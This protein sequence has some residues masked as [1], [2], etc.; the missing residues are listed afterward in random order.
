M[1]LIIGEL[2][3]TF[4]GGG[5]V[6]NEEILKRL[7]FDF[8]FIPSTWNIYN[9]LT[10]YKYKEKLIEKINKLNLNVPDFIF[11]ILELKKPMSRLNI[12]KLINTKI[13]N[14][15]FD[16]AYAQE[17]LLED[18]FL[19]SKI[20]SR[21]KGFILQ[22]V[23]FFRNLLEDIKIDIIANKDIQYKSFIQIFLHSLRRTAFRN[24]FL[25][26]IIK[27]IDFV[28]TINPLNPEFILIKKKKELKK[29]IIF[30]G[31]AIG[32]LEKPISSNK[33]DY[34]IYAARAYPTKGFLLLPYI[35]KQVIKIEKD[36]KLFVSTSKDL[37]NP[38]IRRFDKLVN[39]FNLKKNIKYVGLLDKADYAKYVSKAK[40]FVMPSLAESYALVVIESL[41]LRTVFLGLRIPTLEYLYGDLNAVFLSNNISELANNVIKIYKMENE[42]YEQLFS[43]KVEKFLQLH[44]SWDNVA[45]VEEETLLNLLKE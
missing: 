23:W 35:W 20:R 2:P 37:H 27:Q 45:K 40:G 26:Y 6:R 33:E 11:N 16:L 44:R 32:E 34:F 41:Y 14:D 1:I 22:G 13:G 38:Y 21:H 8:I 29:N 36:A 24:I 31:N 39:D 3:V 10:D 18:L 5:P 9:A 7:K 42:E 19:L 28:N 12:A 17:E 30:P 15:L 43:D 4:G 25:H